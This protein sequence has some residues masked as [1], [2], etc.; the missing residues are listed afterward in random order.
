MQM[1]SLLMVV[2]HFHYLQVQAVMY[3]GVM[4]LMTSSKTTT[5]DLARVHAV[6]AHLRSCDTDKLEKLREDPESAYVCDY[7]SRNL[8]QSRGERRQA[9]VLQRTRSRTKTLSG[10]TWKKRGANTTERPG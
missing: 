3:S 2:G 8:T 6:A 7:V 4:D 1:L 5:S 9:E 10:V